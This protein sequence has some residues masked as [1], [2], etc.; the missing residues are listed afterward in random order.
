VGP[1]ALPVYQEVHRLK[2]ECFW[3]F[4]TA[5]STENIEHVFKDVH[6]MIINQHLET[7]G[8]A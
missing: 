1:A 5:T 3:H 6:H 4:T 2:R 8:L 7:L